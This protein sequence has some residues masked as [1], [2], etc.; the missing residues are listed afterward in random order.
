MKGRFI[1]FEGIDG[2]GKSTHIDWYVQRL[3][4]RGIDA[5]RTREPGGTPLAERLR[6]LLLA[7][8]MSLEVELM[9][10]FAA[11]QDHL[12]RLIR[13]SL[14]QGKWVVC[15][16]FTDS[17]W[18][19]QGGGRGASSRRIAALE[20][21]VHGDLQ[22]DR[23]YLF[24]LPSELAAQRRAAARDADRF[25]REDLAFF[26]RVRRVYLERA[27]AEPERFVQVDGRSPIEVVKE[28]LE[29]DLAGLS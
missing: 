2:A 7:E 4:A 8:P 29:K 27:S 14:A 26:E 22:P 13:P 6:D 10:M 11:R 12:E 9:L 5:I 1:S 25:E 19:Y 17:T 18:A 3:R 24:D 16:R 20:D 21:W 23:S 28:L 15:D